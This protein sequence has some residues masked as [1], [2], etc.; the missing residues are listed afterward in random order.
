MADRVY[1]A[2]TLK[3]LKALSKRHGGIQVLAQLDDNELRSSA[4]RWKL[5][6]L[7]AYRLLIRSQKSFLQVLK[8]DH[9]E[10]CPVCH[11]DELRTQRLNRNFVQ[12]LIGE[13]P[14]GLFVKTES[15]LLDLPAGIFWLAL[16]EY[17]P[18]ASR[19]GLSLVGPCWPPDIREVYVRHTQRVYASCTRGLWLWNI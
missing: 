2:R 1:S 6:H 18:D 12:D 4:S 16:V 10:Q 19:S 11:N 8:T 5:R 14:R 13:G 3:D 17:C 9:T 7:I 15:E